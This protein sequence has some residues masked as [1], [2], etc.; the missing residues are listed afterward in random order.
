MS[1]RISGIDHLVLT[2]ADIAATLTFYRDVL[3]MQPETFTPPDGSTRWALAFG[4]QKINLHQAG[5]EFDPKAAHVRPG[6]ADLCFLSDTPLALWQD[7]LRQAGVP[8]ELGPLRRTGA[9]GP[10]LSLYIRDPDGNLVEI[11]N[12]LA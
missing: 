12:L 5:A 11:S 8:V 1:P 7:H 9:T 4:S 2:V 10:L 6:S 3:G